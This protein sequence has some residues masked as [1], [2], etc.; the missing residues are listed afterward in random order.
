LARRPRKSGNDFLKN[1][2]TF[3]GLLGGADHQ[4]EQ[5]QGTSQAGWSLSV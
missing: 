5:V 1:D 4:S 2:R 3:R